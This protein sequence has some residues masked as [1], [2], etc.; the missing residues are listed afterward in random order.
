VE[1]EDSDIP[2]VYASDFTCV[3]LVAILVVQGVG[4][5]CTSDVP[6]T[7]LTCANDVGCL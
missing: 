4:I 6:S 2:L 1:E 7:I 3:R 5:V